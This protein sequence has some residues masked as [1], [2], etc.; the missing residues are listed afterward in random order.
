MK[1]FKRLAIAALCAL[2]ALTLVTPASAQCGPDKPAPA[3]TKKAVKPA[4]VAI[5]VKG[6]TCGGCA[7]KVQT[8]LMT[9]NGVL[10]ATVTHDPGKAVIHYDAALV[11]TAELVAAITAQGYTTGKP[12]KVSPKRQS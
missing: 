6:M 12:E 7:N 5:S 10:S 11:T 2:G 9:I 3:K 4:D 8:A 1:Q